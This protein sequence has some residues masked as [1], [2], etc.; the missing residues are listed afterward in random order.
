MVFRRPG[1]P[2]LQLLIGF[3]VE[4]DQQHAQCI[5]P[6]AGKEATAIVRG[7]DIVLNR[8]VNAIIFDDDCIPYK[9]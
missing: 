9:R 1:R 3:R 2:A 6:L 4:V 8:F 7:A 5:E